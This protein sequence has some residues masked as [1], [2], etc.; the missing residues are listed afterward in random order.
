MQQ[1]ICQENAR[2]ERAHEQD[3]ADFR[4]ERKAILEG[5][6]M[7]VEEAFAVLQALREQNAEYFALTGKNP[8]ILKPERA[9]FALE[10]KIRQMW[11]C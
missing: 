4:A 1:Q 5:A 6:P 9:A 11:G 10:K 7:S 2:I 8:T 3:I